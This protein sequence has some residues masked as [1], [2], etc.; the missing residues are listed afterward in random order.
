MISWMPRRQRS[1]NACAS[2]PAGSGD[3]P[4][5]SPFRRLISVPPRHEPPDLPE[6]N[7]AGPPII[8]V[9]VYPI[10]LVFH[11][12]QPVTHLVLERKQSEQRSQCIRPLVPPA[13]KGLSQPP[14]GRRPKVRLVQQEP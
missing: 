2:A 5:S 6:L 4:S 12:A 8:E 11:E 9:L 7:E 1:T 10:T 13:E 14:D 3:L